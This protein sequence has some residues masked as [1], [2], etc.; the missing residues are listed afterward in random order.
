MA[1]D[2]KQ[3]ILDNIDD[4]APF[5]NAI[6]QRGREDA[7]NAILIAAGSPLV[8]GRPVPPSLIGAGSPDGKGSPAL[9]SPVRRAPR[10][11]VPKVLDKMLTEHP[12]KTIAEYEELAPSYDN[13]ISIKSVGNEL[14]RHEHTKYR[15]NDDGEWFLINSDGEAEDAA[16]NEQSSASD[17]TN[18]GESLWNRLNQ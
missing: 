11:T 1:F 2:A 7:R 9:K 4:L 17:R 5:I 6:Y 8:T 18:Q 13:R 16:T 3:F 12:G 10:G 14:R 15:R